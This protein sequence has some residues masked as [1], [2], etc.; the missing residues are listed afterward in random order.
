MTQQFITATISGCALK[1]GSKTYSSL[2]QSNL[3]LQKQAELMSCR[4]R[5]VER[6][7]SAA[8]LTDAHP[9]LQDRILLNYTRIENARDV[10]KKTFDFSLCME[11]QHIF[12]FLFPWWDIIK[13]LNTS[14]LTTAVFAVV[15]EF[16]HATE[17][18]NVANA[19]SPC[20]NQP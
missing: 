13:C 8:G 16:Y 1:Q 15:Q 5:A 14:M 4:L 12:S 2:R 3:Q 19:F 20:A 10:R 17:I 11:V 18:C 6:T 7:K 9:G